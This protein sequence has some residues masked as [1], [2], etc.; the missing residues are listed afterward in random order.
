MSDIIR[1]LPES[2]ATRIAAGEVVNRPMSVVKELVENAVDAGATDIQIVI[3]DAGRT[4]IQVID[5]GKGMSPRDARMAFGHHATSKI[6]NADDLFNLTTMGFRGEALPSICSVAQVELITRTEDSELG[7][8]LLIA[9]SKVEL[10]EPHVSAKGSNFMV[11]NLFFNTPARRKFLKSDT[12]ELA[13]IMREFERLALVNNNL[14]LSL[15]TGSRTIDLRPGSFKMRIADLWKNSGIG[16]QLIPVEVETEL[17]KISGF[18]SYPQNAR[19]RG[20]LQ[21]LIVNGRNMTHPSFRKAILNCYEGIIAHDTQ[22]CFFLKFEVDPA[23]IDVNI[24]PN[25]SEIKFEHESTI[26]PILEAAVRGVLGKFALAPSIDFNQDALELDPARDGEFVAAPDDPAQHSY[27]PFEQAGTYNPFARSQDPFKQ[28]AASQGSGRAWSDHMKARQ[29]TA[30]WESLYTNFMS[31][32]AELRQAKSV[33]EPAPLPGTE[34]PASVDAYIQVADKY[35]LKPAQEGVL[36]IDQH[37][38]HV[39]VLYEKYLRQRS[40]SAETLAMQR[41]TF[42]ET[43][44]LSSRQSMQLESVEDELSRVGFLLSHESEGTWKIEGVPAA[45]KDSSAAELLRK[46]ADSVAD[47]A[48]SASV[49]SEPLAEEI[50]SRVALVMARVSAIRRGQRLT[51]AEIQHL[52]QELFALPDPAY[53]PQGNPVF[54]LLP[55]IRLDSLFS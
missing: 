51:Q 34:A 27:N 55:T 37:R 47:D 12:V 4:L 8:R 43:V 16:K 2:V 23:T 17:V 21:Y 9:D 35:I 30:N 50:S 15:N 1:Q 54:R 13:N 20:A 36:V 29:S 52:L 22:P 32:G 11:R 53:T 39:K 7:T 10:Q 42:P 45:L 3:K 6:K 26:R 5:N 31:D 40:L 33:P 41:L 14:H 44:N 18:V 25:K 24:S 48:T 28:P 49:V 19:R 38:A 46:I